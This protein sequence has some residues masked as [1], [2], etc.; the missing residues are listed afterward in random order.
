MFVLSINS[1]FVLKDR[2]NN[3]IAA[4][5]Q[6]PEIILFHQSRRI[7]NNWHRFVCSKQARVQEF[8]RG[9]GGP[10]NLKAFFFMLFTF[11]GGG[12]QLRK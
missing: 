3:V 2:I 7:F 8:V 4:S 6:S 10:Q 1:M 5:M 11:Y 12:G 9:G